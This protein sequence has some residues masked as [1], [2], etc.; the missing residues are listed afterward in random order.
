M[1]KPSS[2]R[3]IP[4][5]VIGHPAYGGLLAK[6]MAEK[7]FN[8]DP[9]HDLVAFKEAS[10]LAFFGVKK[11]VRDKL[12]ESKDEKL[13]WA[14]LCLRATRAGDQKALVKCCRAWHSKSSSALASIAGDSAGSCQKSRRGKGRGA[15]HSEQLCRCNAVITCCR[16]LCHEVFSEAS[17]M[18]GQR[19]RP[20]DHRLPAH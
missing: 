16:L 6:Y 19:A 1:I 5:W 15:R 7:T 12:A 3:R 13:Y 18:A 10:W 2:P 8:G 9:G 17:A 14:M 11:V 20:F 4:P